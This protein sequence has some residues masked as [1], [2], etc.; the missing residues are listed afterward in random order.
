MNL[1]TMEIKGVGGVILINIKCNIAYMTKNM[2]DKSN[3]NVSTLDGRF[4]P[5][6]DYT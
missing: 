1:N 5:V 2:S 6:F 3:I 4:I